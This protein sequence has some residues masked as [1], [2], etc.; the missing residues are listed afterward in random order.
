MSEVKNIPRLRF[1]E[2]VE[3]WK[4]C[5]VEDLFEFKN[6]LNKEKEFFG[7]GIPIINFMDVYKHPHLT[8]KNL[9]GLVD[10]SESEIS[11]FSVIKGDLFFT[12]T[13]ET[14]HDIGMSSSLI[15]DIP[16]CVFS[17]FT[18]RARPQEN[19]FDSKF[20]GYLFRTE[21]IRKEITTKSSMTTRALTSGSLLK[22]VVFNYPN[23]K[24]EQQKIS[25]FLTAVD[26]RIELLE[27]KKTLLETYKKGVMKK[28]FNQEIRFKDDN[29]NNFP[30][31]EEKRLG[32]LLKHV[33][34]R[35]K[36]LNVELVLSVSNTLGFISQKEQFD[37]HRVASKDVSNYKIVCKNQF[38]YNPSRIN[39]GSIALLKDYEIGIVSPMYVIFQTKERLDSTY[40]EYLTQ[41]H[42]FRHYVKIGCSGSVRDSLNF[43]EMEKFKFNIPSLNEQI[44]ISEFLI[45]L[46]NQFD[47]LESQIDK[48]TT[49]KKG[50]L[51]KMFV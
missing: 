40:M 5:K 7:R 11:R 8:S 26:K 21:K 45:S 3:I 2:F 25:D 33:S 49:W 46:D 15:E 51:Q 34:A 32:S 1:P 9:S 50:L 4:S 28:I 23:S 38:G 41:T 13:S 35:N 20:T 12:R 18:L 31:W 47:L 29:G 6:G 36:S 14:I 43:D 30:D 48:S 24:E 27:K 39:V 22:K 16:N 37:K 10:L 42:L 19:I 44:K 17:G